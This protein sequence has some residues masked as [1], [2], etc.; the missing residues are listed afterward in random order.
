MKTGFYSRLAWTGIRQNRKSYVPYILTCTGMVMMFYIIS[1]LTHSQTV[2]SIRGGDS[3]QVILGLGCGVMGVFA[4]IFLFYTHSFLIRR[5]KKEFGLYNILGMGKVNLVRILIWES[6]MIAVTSIGAGLF[7]GIL[8]SKMAELMLIN[9]IGG[10]IGFSFSVESV[11]VIHTLV[12][13]A[14]IF[15]II[16]LNTMR[17]IHVSK[18]VEL[19]HSESVGEKPPKSNWLLAAVGLLV[20]GGAY[21]LAVSTQDPLSALAWFFVAAIMVIVATYLLFIAGSVTLCKLLQKNKRYYYKANHFV[22]VSSMIYRMKRNG[23]GLASICILSTMVL[24]MLSST[25]CLFIG[26][27]DSLRT[28]YPRHIVL[29]TYST[30]GPYT[31]AV[32]AAA[33]KVL[34]ANDVQPENILRYSTLGLAGQFD[35]GHV[36]IEDTNLRSFTRS[37]N[38]RQIY[39]IALEDYNRLMGANETLAPDEALIYS[40]KSVYANTSITIDGL[41]ILKIKKAVSEFAQGG[42][43]AVVGVPSLFVFVPDFA[44]VVTAFSAKTTSSGEKLASEHTYYGFDLSCSDEHQIAVEKALTAEIESL[45]RADRD[46]ATVRVEGVAAERAD[47]YAL[48]GG[49]FFL[50]ILLGIVFVFAT[51]LMMYYKQISEGY[52]DR[53]RFEIMQKVG[54]TKKEIRQSINSQV[55]TVFFAPLLAAGVHITFAFPMIAKLLA[56]FSLTNTGLLMLVTL[57]CYVVFALFYVLVYRITS[58]AYYDIVSST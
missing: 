37:S 44:S 23:A 6:L 53:S 50:G 26:T 57:L 47:F 14:A 2:R 8:F 33:G 20:L 27:E 39:F 56:L 24:V 40:P 25:T 15:L 51:V 43:R 41:G 36:T 38:I 18:P 17:Q 10:E 54:M 28:I 19:L 46:F 3:L 30:Q 52:E 48:N 12:L 29:D 16:L 34:S 31:E 58:H 32:Q 22:S 1:F 11:S 13:F 35:D 5:R 49:L 4:V 21:Y 42:T 7:C 9:T 55:L 45:R